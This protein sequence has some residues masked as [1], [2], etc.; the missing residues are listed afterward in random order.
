MGTNGLLSGQD[1]PRET[2]YVDDD[3]PTDFP[4]IAPFLADL[5]T[6]GG[7]G[8]IYYRQDGASD[9]L[10]RAAG[11]IRA[12]FP[13]AAFAPTRA[14]VATWE[15][16]AAYEAVSR[17][18]EP[19]RQVRARLVGPRRAGGRSGPVRSGPPVMLNGPARLLGSDLGWARCG[20]AQASASTAHGQVS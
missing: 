4:A 9:V 7:R 19:S 16:V 10:S 13:S 14:V 3:L 8:Q 12:G 18:A 6:S 1:F 11:Y 20:A 2:Q 17:D 15:D 5:D